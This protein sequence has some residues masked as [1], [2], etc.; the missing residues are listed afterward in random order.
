VNYEKHY[1][2]QVTQLK[3]KGTKGFL[4]Y[5]PF[6]N[7]YFFRVYLSDDKKTYKDYDLKCEDLEIEIIDN[8]TSFFEDYIDYTKE[9]KCPK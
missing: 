6:D 1:W 8:F 7:V 9:V 4:L 3:T 2:K 5:N